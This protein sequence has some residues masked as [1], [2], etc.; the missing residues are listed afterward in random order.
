MGI[1]GDE[2]NSP[3]S[4]PHPIPFGHTHAV[5]KE[6][7]IALRTAELSAIA[8]LFLFKAAQLRSTSHQPQFLLQC[9]AQHLAEKDVH[10]LNAGGGTRRDD[11]QWVGEALERAPVMA[12]E[13]GG[14]HAQLA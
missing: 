2:G 9:A 14:D 7:T 1:G 13:R 3:P 8:S 6:E 4:P 5:A 10:L 11:E 12:G